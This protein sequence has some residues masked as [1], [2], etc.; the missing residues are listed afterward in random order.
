MAE[1]NQLILFRE[2][3]TVWLRESNKTQ[4]AILLSAEANILCSGH[5]VM[6]G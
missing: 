4:N 5:C 6:E 3:I 1:A 2:I